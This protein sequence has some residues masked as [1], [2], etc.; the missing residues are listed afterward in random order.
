M[1]D[2]EQHRVLVEKAPFFIE[3][4][5]NNTGFWYGG[6]SGDVFPARLGTRY[7]LGIRSKYLYKYLI[8]GFYVVRFSHSDGSYHDS[9]VLKKDS[10]RI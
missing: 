4:C 2:N 1:N 6:R 5:T 8:E 9:V 3:I 10:I 7:D